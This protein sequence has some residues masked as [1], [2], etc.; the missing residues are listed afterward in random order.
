MSSELW[1]EEAVS[2]GLVGTRFDGGV[3]HFIS[4]GSTNTLAIE[5]AQAGEPEGRVWVADEQTAGRGRGGHTWHSVAGDGLYLSALTRPRLGLVE[6]LWIALGTGLAVQA[7]VHQVTGLRPD[8]RWPNDLLIEG[9]KFGGILV[10]TSSAAAG[11]GGA[12]EMLRYAIIG[13]GLNVGHQAFPEELRETATSLL[14]ETGTLWPREDLLVALLRA[15]DEELDR[16]EEELIP[17]SPSFGNSGD[18]NR[19]LARFAAASSWVRGK[20]VRVGEGDGYTGVTAGLD[21]RGFLRVLGDDGKTH[22]VLSGG[23]RPR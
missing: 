20:A 12:A 1:D 6:A 3:K 23:V 21:P 16:L 13:I 19:L 15:L 8:I 18:G 17:G 22:T 10:E 2:A 14:L 11:V 5:A 7:A 4:V 9:K